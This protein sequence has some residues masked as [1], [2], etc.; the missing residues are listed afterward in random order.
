LTLVRNVDTLPL[1]YLVINNLT[2]KP[3]AKIELDNILKKIKLDKMLL[4][5]SKFLP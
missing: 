3:W 2:E 1:S 5:I 4:P